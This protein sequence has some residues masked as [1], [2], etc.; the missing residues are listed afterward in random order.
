MV[1]CF[2]IGGLRWG[3]VRLLSAGI[4][5][6]LDHLLALWLHNGKLIRTAGLRPQ[7][8]TIRQEGSGASRLSAALWRLRIRVAGAIRAAHLFAVILD[9]GFGIAPHGDRLIGPVR[10]VH[11]GIPG[12]VRPFDGIDLEMAGA[13][14]RKE[15]VG[16][17]SKSRHRHI[18][19][20]AD[21]LKGRRIRILN[22]LNDVLVITA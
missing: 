4:L 1:S 6:G 2:D 12:D 7:P 20:G 15:K 10:V 9:G 14:V 21:V 3:I 16:F 19:R 11:D 8:I 18:R 17:S 5:P 22:L 13:P